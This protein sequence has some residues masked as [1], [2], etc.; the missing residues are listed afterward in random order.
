MVCI[1]H[2]IMNKKVIDNFSKLR[3]SAFLLPLFLIILIVFFLYQNN[4]LN[5]DGYVKVQLDWF[6]FLNAELSKYPILQQN[7]T[8]FGDAFI[9]LSLLSIFIVYAPKLWEAL[10]PASLLSLLFSNLLKNLFKVPRPAA[11]LDSESFTII[12]RKLAAFNSLPSG[13]SITVFTTLTI[14][15]FAFMPQKLINKILWILLYLMIGTAL[16]FT[17]VGVGAHFP[18]DTIFGGI[19]GYCTALLGIFSI[20]KFSLFKWIEN[21]KFYPVFMTIFV[22]SVIILVQKIMN[23]PLPIYYLTLIAILFSLFIFT[24]TYVQKQN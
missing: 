15:L 10:I 18:L 19:I 5:T 3:F 21:K 13:H 9:V 1:K 14:I 4:A 6:Y 23:E 20:R 2:L 7:L 8:Y 11:I 22:V 24:K 16:I 12:G 17:R